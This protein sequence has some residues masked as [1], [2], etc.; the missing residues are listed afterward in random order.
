M[1]TT[2]HLDPD[3][4]DYSVDREFNWRGAFGQID[5]AQRVLENNDVK[6]GDLFIYQNGQYQIYVEPN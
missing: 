6:E 3:I 5:A 2:C 4:C 1:D